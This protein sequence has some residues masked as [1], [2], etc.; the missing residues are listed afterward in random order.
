MPTALY[1]MVTAC[2]FLTM[3]ARHGSGEVK[4]KQPELDEMSVIICAVQAVVPRLVASDVPIFLDIVAE[5][6]PQQPLVKTSDDR[7]R[8]AIEEALEKQNLQAPLC[9]VEKGIQLYETQLLRH[10]ILVV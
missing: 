1:D 6:F 4:K 9:F 3:C 10:G 2:S 5:V 8:A 7:L